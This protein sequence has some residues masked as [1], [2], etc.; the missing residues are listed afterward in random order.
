MLSLN[1]IELIIQLGSDALYYL[2]EHQ[3]ATVEEPAHYIAAKK[4]GKSAVSESEAER[5]EAQ[6]HHQHLPRLK[7][8]GILD[9]DERRGDVSYRSPSATFG[10]FLDL[11]RLV[12][13]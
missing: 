9:V 4:S 7:E 1:T 6:L 8:Y 10:V 2:D 13:G 3:I 5:L 12:E 11:C